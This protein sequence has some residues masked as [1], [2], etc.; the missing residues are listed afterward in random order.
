MSLRVTL[1][2]VFGLVAAAL[3]SVPAAFANHVQCG[4]VI[5][6][7]TTLDSD[8]VNCPGDGVVIGASAITLDLAGHTVDG[9]GS[10]AG[11]Q[12]VDNGAGHDAV[13]V[14]GGSIRDFQA[15]VLFRFADHGA[16]R[17]LT[18]SDSGI[19][20]YLDN[21]DSNTVERNVLFSGIL[22][23]GDSD[24]NI[25][26]RNEISGYGTGVLV[27]GTPNRASDTVITRNRIVGN[28]VGDSVG[29]FLG[30]NS[31]TV[32]RDN[33]I[34]N[35]GDRGIALVLDPA[36]T[37]IERNRIRGNGT[38]VAVDGFAGDTLVS[39][40]TLDANQV[41]G[42]R[43]GASTRGTSVVGNTASGN[44]DDGIDADSVRTTITQN[45]ANDNGD[46]GIEAA[47]GVTDGGNNKARGNGNPAQC[48]GVSC[49]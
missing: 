30:A 3:F 20:L 46:L 34:S 43:V 48:V 49:K 39:R 4:D 2:V 28:G 22:C 29:V 9:T 11:G 27:D 14:K 26:D 19:A 10:D 41:D 15:G 21:S 24:A 33:E 13:A 16:L 45:I 6:Q 44:G 32:I 7:S 25:I 31:D 35:N 40:N 18:V 37:V 36:R 8:L 42:V 38:G 12:G 17:D 1:L 47:L 23:F 5:T